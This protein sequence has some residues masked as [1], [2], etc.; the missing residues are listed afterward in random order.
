MNTAYKIYFP[1]YGAGGFFGKGQVLVYGEDYTLYGMPDILSAMCDRFLPVK[2]TGNVQYLVNI[3]NHSVVVTLINN[4]GVSKVDNADTVYN[5]DLRQPVYV[6]F[7]G[8]SSVKS[9]QSWLT[10]KNYEKQ[11]GAFIALEPG[12]IEILEFTVG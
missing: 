9:I 4:L 5:H 8:E 3:R 7:A 10:G 12:E 1:E 11:Q 2:V 6:E